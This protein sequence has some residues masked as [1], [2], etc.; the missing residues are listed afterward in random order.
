M[1][2]SP[3]LLTKEKR[4]SRIFSS[5]FCSMAIL[6]L[7]ALCLLN[8]FTIDLYSTTVLLKVVLPGAFCF[9]ILGYIIGFI[10]DN[11]ENNIVETRAIDDKKA[12]EIPSMFSSSTSCF[13]E[14]NSETEG[15]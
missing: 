8:N 9:W 6:A 14:K 2:S 12:Y 15:L 13:D 7:S 3:V 10:L 4:Y 1:K 5:L 11:K